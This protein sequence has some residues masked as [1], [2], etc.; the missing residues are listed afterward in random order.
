MSSTYPLPLDDQKR[1]IKELWGDN[2]KSGIFSVLGA[3]EDAKASR[4]EPTKFIR[5]FTFYFKVC[6]EQSWTKHAIRTHQELLELVRFL[7]GNKDRSKG[8]IRTSLAS[9]QGL[10]RARDH[11]QIDESLELALR[12]W[13]L[14][15]FRGHRSFIP[16]QTA[17]YWPENE[18]YIVALRHLF[19]KAAEDPPGKLQISQALTAY[20]LTQFGG[21]TIK[22]TWNL[23]DHLMLTH[24]KDRKL[25][26][27][28][29]VTILEALG[30][31]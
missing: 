30:S 4:F 15:S 10:F 6:R 1:I 12:L 23:V 18:S 8:D 13:L 27:C 28:H 29:P 16:G 31:R 26:I 25:V 7:K 20:S 2:V 3:S 22:W 11:N 21:F 5:Y 14:V 17:V 19:P 9:P 24:G